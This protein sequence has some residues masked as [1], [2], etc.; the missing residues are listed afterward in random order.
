MEKVIIFG[1]SEGAILGHFYLTH[2][3]PYQVVAFT[4]DRDYIKEETMCGL[5]IVPFEEVE[6]IYP[7]DDYKM[8]IAVLF[9]RVNRTRAEKYYQAK[10]KGYE[11]INYTSSKAITWPGLEMGDNCFIAEGAI[12]G[13]FTK[14]GNNVMIRPGSFIGHHSVIKDHCWLGAHTVVLG[15]CSVESYCFLGANSTIADSVTVA[16]E[17]VIGAGALIL[18][19]T[20]EK[21]VYRGNP[22]VLLPVSSDKLH[23]ILFTR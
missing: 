20:Q 15:R 8:F 14:I 1:A 11:L 21:G 3:S 22:P 2:D 5:P 17:C 16:R 6:T 4:V 18:K 12:C 7:P 9:G 19:D 13:P 10:E 23:K